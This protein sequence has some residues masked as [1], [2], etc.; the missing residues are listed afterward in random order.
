MCTAFTEG[1][2]GSED[3]AFTDFVA[4]FDRVAMSVSPGEYK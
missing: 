2:D 3:G 4:G 1:F